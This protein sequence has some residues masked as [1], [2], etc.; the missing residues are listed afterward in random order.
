MTLKKLIIVANTIEKKLNK[1]ADVANTDTLANIVNAVSSKFSDTLKLYMSAHMKK[2]NI[3]ELQCRFFLNMKFSNKKCV[4]CKVTI[5]PSGPLNNNNDFKD[6]FS[7][8]VSPLEP[9][10]KATV[11]NVNLRERLPVENDYPVVKLFEHTFYATKST[12]ASNA[13]SKLQSV[14]N[15][16]ERN[17]NLN[18]FAAVAG[19]TI[20]DSLN[21]GLQGIAKVTIEDMK[22]EENALK[23]IQTPSSKK[24]RRVL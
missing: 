13:V 7:T 16:I 9:N 1:F 15:K 20:N 24:N 3:S 21:Y 23:I 18:K 12:T 19:T 14:A 17:L 22:I 11:D 6:S 8:L 4:D 10:I 5:A 2:H